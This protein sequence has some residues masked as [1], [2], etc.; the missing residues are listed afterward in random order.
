MNYFYNIDG[1][2]YG[3]LPIEQLI[4]II[5]PETLIWNEDGSMPD[6]KQAREVADF[7]ELS[8]PKIVAE[9]SYFYIENQISLGPLTISE[10]IKKI[11]KN[12]LVWNA[13]GS[14]T[15][16]AAARDI[17]EL[18]T[19]FRNDDIERKNNHPTPP[20]KED[21][22][23]DNLMSTKVSPYEINLILNTSLK[24]KGFGSKGNYYLFIDNVFKQTV[25]LDGFNIKI[26]VDKNN[27]LIE[28]VSEG[29]YNNGMDEASVQFWLSEFPNDITEILLP[30]LDNTLNYKIELEYG[31]IKSSFFGGDEMGILPEPKIIQPY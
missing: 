12:T 6:W 16:W 22:N 25:K 24:T 7:N 2:T 18:K 11:N 3:P 28:F 8:Q 31:A 1:T 14:M 10:L 20:M 30:N 17:P 4:K 19:L 9:N 26:T 13:N 29:C 5:T 21:S 27:P 23:I 15:E